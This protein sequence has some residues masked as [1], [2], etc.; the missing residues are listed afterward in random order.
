VSFSYFIWYRVRVDERETETVIRHM[1][2]RLACRSGVGG[3]LLKKHEETRLW[4][5][6]YE[7]IT[8]PA[9]FEHLLAQAVDEFDV[10]MFCDDRRHAECFVQSH[11][12]VTARCAE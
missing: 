9:G 1:M 10:E 11:A 3:R 7:G 5:E 8:D 12:G 6:V 2:T 4:M